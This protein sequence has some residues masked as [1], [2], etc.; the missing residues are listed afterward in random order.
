[1]TIDK[2]H[3]IIFA[4]QWEQPAVANYLCH[5]VKGE[6]GWSVNFTKSP[7]IEVRAD[8]SST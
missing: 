8:T 4:E 2:E 7:L 5:V 6:P 1:M 3:K